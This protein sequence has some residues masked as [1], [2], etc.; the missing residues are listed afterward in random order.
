M[1]YGSVS[2]VTTSGS[3]NSTAKGK[4][5]T[6]KK[7]RRKQEEDEGNDLA[8]IT[9]QTMFLYFA[10]SCESC[11]YLLYLCQKHALMS[12]MFILAFIPA[13]SC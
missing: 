10:P 3:V 5:S 6:A 13:T 8:L 1:T 12:E 7:K 11:F 9:I 4:S 2:T